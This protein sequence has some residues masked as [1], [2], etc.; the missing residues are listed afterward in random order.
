MLTFET[1][2]D[3]R[4]FVSQETLDIWMTD[5]RVEVE[6][7]VMTLLPDGQRFQLKTAVHFLEEVAG[8]GDDAE[9]IGK[10]KGLKSQICELR[11]LTP[12]KKRKGSRVTW[13]FDVHDSVRVDEIA[14]P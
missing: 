14:K 11:D 12:D 7:E 3:H 6:G 9:L 1:V 10:V 5:G 4:L 8:G 2:P 13:A